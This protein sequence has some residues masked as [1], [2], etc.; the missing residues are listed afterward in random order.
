MIFQLP[1]LTPVYLKNICAPDS[2]YYAFQGFRS[3]LL[4]H[5]RRVPRAIEPAPLRALFMVSDTEESAKE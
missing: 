3:Q 4:A 5:P 1:G 2:I